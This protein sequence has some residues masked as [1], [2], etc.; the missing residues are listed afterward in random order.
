MNTRTA[1]YRHF[2]ASGALLYVGISLSAVQRLEQ[3]KQSAVW[4][5]NIGRVDVEWF[6][7]RGAALRAE[8]EAIRSE[9]PAHNKARPRLV[10]GPPKRRCC[11]AIRHCSSGR[12]NGWF[13]LPGDAPHLMGWFRAL[14]PGERFELVECEPGK[15]W[16]IGDS[17]WFDS[18]NFNEWTKADPDYEAADAYDA[19]KAA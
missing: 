5:A 18:L 8:A 11:E 4:F 2:D 1:L 3:H 10:S 6:P 17:D 15:A 16:P 7:S 13:F 19:R 9:N 14:F 12:L